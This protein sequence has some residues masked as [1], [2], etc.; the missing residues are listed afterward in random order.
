MRA[1]RSF[2][3]E[4]RWLC[5]IFSAYCGVKLA[6]SLVTRCVAERVRNGEAEN[7]LEAVLGIKE[8]LQMFLEEEEIEEIMKRVRMKESGEK[9]GAHKPFT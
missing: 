2:L 3:D 7:S 9:E 1:D 6:E 4:W 5:E 8:Q